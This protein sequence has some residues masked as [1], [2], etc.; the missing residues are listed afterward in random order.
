MVVGC[1]IPVRASSCPTGVSSRQIGTTVEPHPPAQKQQFYLPWYSCPFIQLP[2]Y[3]VSSCQRLT[4]VYSVWNHIHL[5]KR[6]NF[7]S[8]GILLKTFSRPV[9]VSSSQRLTTVDSV[10]NHIH[11][12]KRRVLFAVFFFVWA[13]SCPVGVFPVRDSPLKPYQPTQEEIL[14]AVVFLSM[15]SSCPVTECPPGRDSPLWTTSACTKRANYI[16]NNIL[17]Q[18]IQLPSWSVL[19]TG[20]YHCG[21]NPPTPKGQFY[22]L[23]VLVRREDQRST[24]LCELSLYPTS[25]PA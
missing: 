3:R 16:C 7:I 11:L 21:P 23:W 25:P 14:F 10:G 6:G 15:A 22:L 19:Q 4:T 2:G 5:C 20:I 13:S 18:D 24:L 9:G 8:C 17:V 1:G 12:H